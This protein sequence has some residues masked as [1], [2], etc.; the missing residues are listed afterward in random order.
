M[1]CLISAFWQVKNSS[2]GIWPPQS[3]T[4]I[5]RG[6]SEFRPGEVICTPPRGPGLI[7]N[8]MD[9]LLHY[10]N[11]DEKYPA[12]PLLKMCIAR[13]QFEAIQ[14]FQDGNGL[15]G[16][17]LNLLYLVNKRLAIPIN[18]ISFK[19][20]YYHLGAVIQPGSWKAWVMYTLDAIQHTALLTGQFIKDIVKQMNA[21]LE[22]GKSKIKWYNKEV[23]EAIFSQPYLKPRVIGTLIERSSRSTLSKYMNEL[24]KAQILSPKK[25]GNEV[26]YLNDDLIRILQQ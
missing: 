16:R 4:T 6:Q 2:A 7:E 26:Y 17:I 8:L 9:N 23:N 21:T 25:D 5:K 13:Y 19:V 15:T 11:D 24:V 12:D 1:D 18:F 20:Y 3:F 14:P 10:L 22:Y